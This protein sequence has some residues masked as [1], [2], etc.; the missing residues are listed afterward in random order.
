MID[1]TRIH[2][3]TDFV[4]NYKSFLTRIKETGQP[5]VL[6]VNGVPEAVLVDAKSYQEMVNAL[7][8]ERFVKAVNEGIADMK[9]GRGQPLEESFADIRREYGLGRGE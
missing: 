8:H 3:V 5:E 6:T 2:P 7:E 4:R 9:A 1:L